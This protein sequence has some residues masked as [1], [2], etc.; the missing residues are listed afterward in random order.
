[1][2]NVCV[3]FIILILLTAL[4]VCLVV[5]QSEEVGYTTLL[6]SPGK[7]EIVR[8]PPAFDFTRMPGRGRI[9]SLPSFHP[10]SQKDWQVDLRS[11]DLSTLDVRDRL[12]DLLQA[13]FDTSTVWPAQLPPKFDVRRIMELG[14][15]P[16]LG[17]KDV[18]RKGITGA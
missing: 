13:D 1:M 14:K 2:K 5:A 18:H 16:G 7:M 11:C 9:A 6:S 12:S 17:L 4:G 8:H 3:V 15:N 10:N